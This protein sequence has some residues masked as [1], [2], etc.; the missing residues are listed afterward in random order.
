M[1]P[2]KQPKVQQATQQQ[3]QEKATLPQPP[4]AVDPWAGT[5]SLRSGRGA[6][7]TVDPARLAKAKALLDSADGQ[8]APLPVGASWPLLSVVTPSGLQPHFVAPS[9][10]A[11]GAVDSRGGW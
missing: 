4:P 9:A 8:A 5:S 7:L 2:S 6:V 3:P 10:A 11:S 1:Q